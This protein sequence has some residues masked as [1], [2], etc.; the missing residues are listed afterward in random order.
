MKGD[1]I[2]TRDVEVIEMNELDAAGGEDR[3]ATWNISAK[4]A[5]PSAKPTDWIDGFRRAEA[6]PPKG[7]NSGYQTT[8][9]PTIP[10]GDHQY[11]LKAANAKTANTALA[12]ELKGRHLQMIAFGGAIGTGLFVA[13][14]ASLSKGGPA[15]LLLSYVVIGVM[16]YCT[17]Q[18]LGELCVL[19]PVAGSF[20]AFSTRFLDPSWGFAMGWNYCLQWLFVLPLE[21]IAAAYTISYWNENISK[22]VF[23]A[24][25]LIFIIIIN[26]FGVKA[27]GEA[28]FIF[29][30]IKV[31]AIIGFILL[32]AVINIGG[33]PDT[34]YIGG[35][36][37]QDPGA[38]KNG[39]KGFCSVLVTSSASFTGTELIGLA[40]AETVNPRK[41]LP[42]AIKQ[43]FWRITIFYITSLLL[44]GLLVPSSEPRLLEGKSSADASASPFVIAIETAG[45]TILPSVMNA[46]ILIAV[47]SVG[48]SAVYG[49]SRTLLALA[50]QAHAPVFFSYIDKHG[51]PLMA[52]LLAAVIGVLA[53]LA[54]LEVHDVI[55]NWLLSISALS[56]LFTWGSICLC[57]IR[58]RKAWAHNSNTLEQLPFRSNVG[59]IG[60]WF[61]L[62]GYIMVLASQIWIAVSPLDTTASE[63]T[64]SDKVQTFFLRI[65]AVPIILVFYVLH[66]IW[67]RTRGIKVSEMDIKTGR[68]YF[69]VYIDTEQEREEKMRW[70]F[71]KR[72]YQL[73]C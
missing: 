21:I 34:G 39:F 63:T 73:V 38:F 26:L 35:Q 10:A 11:D 19:F 8:P 62:V 68:R 50:Q 45:T 15:T 70:P 54:D 53:F 25:F 27:Y 14:G 12:R 23:V 30:I 64:T 55:F 58:F 6:L 22:A 46:V 31:T 65:M 2:L 69:R 49:S 28:E 48:N 24:I 3:G 1:I 29:S 56:T 59:V 60:S 67:F 44:V 18:S 41:S 42:T 57:H 20:S 71:W 47:I 51:R 72:L 32:A 13:S 9:P 16:Q 17:M 4:L 5:D 66:K 43:V 40:A 52:I 7:R 33:K 36:Y 37:W 61:G